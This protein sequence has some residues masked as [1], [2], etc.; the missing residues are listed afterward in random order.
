MS[1]P[2]EVTPPPVRHPRD[3]T[4]VEDYLD[5]N[6]LWRRSAARRRQ[7]RHMRTETSAPPLLSMGMLPFLLLMAGMGI[8]AFMIIIAA[9][10]GKR[11]QDRQ[12]EAPPAGTAPSGWFEGR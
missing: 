4:R 5:L 2:D 7:R 1:K 8:L 3:W 9:I 12:S 10:P 6:R 11:T